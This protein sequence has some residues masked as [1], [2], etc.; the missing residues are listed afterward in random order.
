MAKRLNRQLALYAKATAA[1][2]KQGDGKAGEAVQFVKLNNP[3]AVR[4]DGR[5]FDGL[6]LNSRGYRAFAAALYDALG[7][8]LVSVEWKIW[9]AQ[10]AGGMT[11]GAEKSGGAV[12]APMSG[13]GAT[14]GKS[15]ENKK[16][17]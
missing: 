14:Q 2:G 11:V 1:S 6:H 7:P 4:D 9:K 8:M 16:T 13:F 5:A 10:L 17:D 15:K 12:A 3:R